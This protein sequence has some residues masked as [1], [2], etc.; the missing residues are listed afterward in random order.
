MAIKPTIQN[1]KEKR[2]EKVSGKK[3]KRLNSLI[4]EHTVTQSLWNCGNDGKDT[5]TLAVP[6]ELFGRRKNCWDS[7]KNRKW[8]TRIEKVKPNNLFETKRH[9]VAELVACRCS[10]FIV[11]ISISSYRIVR[12]DTFFSHIFWIFHI[13]QMMF[14]CIQPFFQQ[15]KF[16]L[17]QC[18]QNSR[19]RFHKAE[20]YWTFRRSNKRKNTNIFFSH[21]Y[22][23][24]L[25]ICT[26]KTF[27]VRTVALCHSVRLLILTIVEIVII[28]IEC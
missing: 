15:C 6:C 27:N 2:K 21:S 25:K 12:R 24:R 5:M 19:K 17:R 14:E 11:H 10:L 20:K 26:R 23:V 22:H 1:K 13:V 28:I 7:E 3:K 18:S 4:Q 9:C 16:P 8:K